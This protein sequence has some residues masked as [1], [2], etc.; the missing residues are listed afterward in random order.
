[1][2][3]GEDAGPRKEEMEMAKNS[4]QSRRKENG[5]R[6]EFNNSNF[7]QPGQIYKVSLSLEAFKKKGELSSAPTG[8]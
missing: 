8:A 2:G 5:T 6:G 3:G 4:H 1:M 7:L